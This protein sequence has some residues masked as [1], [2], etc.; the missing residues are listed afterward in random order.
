MN[1]NNH[2][3]EFYPAALTISG[4]DSG[5]SA[6]I[7]ADLRT[8]NAYGVFGCSAITA[9]VS[10]N[11]RQTLRT[12]LTDPDS[13][14][15]QIDACMQEINIHFA[16]CGML[17]S[18]GIIRTVAARISEYNTSL[19]CDPVIFTASGREMPDKSAFTLLCDL[20]FPLSS[21]ITP[22]AAE[23]EIIC[24]KKI[25]SF[26]DML[27]SAAAISAE[28]GTSVIIRGGNI[29]TGKT[30]ADAVC[31]QGRL[32][33]LYSPRSKRAG[34]AAAHGAGCT[35][36]AALTAGAAMDF[37]WKQALCEAKAFVHGSMEETVHI[38]D[39]SDVM[40]PPTVDNIR[41][42]HLEEIK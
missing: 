32:Y 24:G 19:I 20:I 27:K 22:A 25:S 14:A 36:S 10:Q 21:W 2:L 3:H 30:A 8:F 33:K 34:E 31:H 42:I 5:G 40:Y 9:V 4:S 11:P 6:G 12:D 37:Q 29:A 13:V 7:Q 35:F 26:D 39:N 38:G 28:F 16:K 15:A 17:F 18:D 41:N 1:D 23:A